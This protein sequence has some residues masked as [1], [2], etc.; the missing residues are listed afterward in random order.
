[1]PGARATAAQGLGISMGLMQSSVH[2][3]TR[4]LPLIYGEKNAR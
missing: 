2:A 1:M 3:H 4:R